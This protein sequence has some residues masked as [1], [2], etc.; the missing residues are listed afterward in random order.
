MPNIKKSP[1]GI[2]RL[3]VIDWTKDSRKGGGRVLVIRDED[4]NIEV[5]VQDDGRTLKVFIKDAE[6]GII[7]HAISQE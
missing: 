5:D 4:I 7:N 2:T 6:N 1:N 3:E